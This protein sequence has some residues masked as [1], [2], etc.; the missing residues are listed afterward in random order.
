MRGLILLLA[1][2][3]SAFAASPTVADA[4]DSSH[5]VCAV[6][7]LAYQYALSKQPH[8]APLRRLF[9]ALRLHSLCGVALPSA[10]SPPRPDIVDDPNA[11]RIDPVNGDDALGDGRRTPFRTVFSA[12]VAARRFTP[13]KPLVL[14][15]GVHYLNETLALT[16][17]DSGFSISAASGAGKAWLSGGV[18]LTG[19]RW[20]KNART[21]IFSATV[22]D[23]TVVDIPGLLTVEADNSPTRLTRA[24]YPNG[25]WETDMWGLCSTNACLDVGPAYTTP[26]RWGG[27][28]SVSINR[29]AAIPKARTQRRHCFDP[30]LTHLQALPS[31]PPLP[32]S[33]PS[34]CLSGLAI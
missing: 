13:T 30:F 1:V 24:R 33:L 25:N 22:T 14:A 26:E 7:K 28:P 19:L 6:R 5:T 27:D 29:A 32:P 23:P 15:D 9:D 12:M 11:L 3:A 8:H 10:Q 4:G 34:I 21:G 31:L 17:A 18:A 2:A 16:S 20:T